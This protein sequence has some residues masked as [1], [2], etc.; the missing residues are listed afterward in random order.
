MTIRGFR[1]KRGL[2]GERNGETKRLDGETIEERGGRLETNETEDLEK[3][4][5]AR[6]GGISE[7]DETGGSEKGKV[8]SKE[9]PSVA[10][11]TQYA[12]EANFVVGYKGRSDSSAG[13]RVSSR[14]PGVMWG[15]VAVV[16]LSANENFHSSRWA[17]RQCEYGGAC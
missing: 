10:S 4:D 5:C 6:E 9:S 12:E 8:S 3:F 11:C 14:R 17:P 15:V 2:S 1:G 7:G 13:W 16:E